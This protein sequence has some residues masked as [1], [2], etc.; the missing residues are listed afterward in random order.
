M[1]SE[2]EWH[3]LYNRPK[4]GRKS[5]QL[6]EMARPSL[7]LLHHSTL[8]VK[9]L[10]ASSAV[11]QHGVQK[12]ECE[13]LIWT[14]T[15]WTQLS[16]LASLM[17]EQGAS[18]TQAVVAK[19]PGNCWLHTTGQSWL[20][21]GS[22]TKEMV[23]KP[24]RPKQKN[25][26]VARMEEERH[27]ITAV[28]QQQQDRWTTWEAVTNRTIT[29]ADLW[30]TPQARLSLHIRVTYNLLP[31]PWDL[32]PWYGVKVPC[33]LCNISNTDLKHI[34]SDCKNALSQGVY[35]KLAETQQIG[36]LEVTGLTHF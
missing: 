31:T 14:G 35:N 3:H 33:Q 12:G 9:H 7:M 16:K 27:E 34:L 2:T 8:W 24:T 1:V 13:A 23:Q 36:S 30:R 11:N 21:M 18:G 6:L 19:T 26:V 20:R 15:P 4:T 25:L 29:W 17:F 5:Q 32:L 28:S 22:C 10:K